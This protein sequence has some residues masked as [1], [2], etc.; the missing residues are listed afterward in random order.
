MEG[1]L[2]AER[3]GTYDLVYPEAGA[4]VQDADQL[5]EV[6]ERLLSELLPLLPQPPAGLGISCAMHGVLLLDA[7]GKPTGP[8]LTWGDVRAQAV[9]DQFFT[10][11]A[12]PPTDPYGNAGAPHVAPG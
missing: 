1:T 12:Y 10:A 4:A 3:T 8:I 11:P 9:M 5:V 2:L 7:D 6:A